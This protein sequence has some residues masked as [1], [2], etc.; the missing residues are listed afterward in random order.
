MKMLLEHQPS[1]LIA[2]GST[3][4]QHLVEIHFNEGLLDSIPSMDVN[5]HELEKSNE[6][7]IRFTYQ[8]EKEGA[9]FACR[10]LM[11]FGEKG[12]SYKE[13]MQT[14]T[15]YIHSKDEVVGQG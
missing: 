1:V 9:I 5:I 7:L 3:S 12:D 11:Y 13:F 4:F 6:P 15:Q 14:V 2:C 10:H 8:N